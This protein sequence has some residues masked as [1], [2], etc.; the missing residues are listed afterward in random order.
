[1][2]SNFDKML[3]KTQ[4]HHHPAGDKMAEAG[5]PLKLLKTHRNMAF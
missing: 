4:I 1:M 5:H 3:R 2:H